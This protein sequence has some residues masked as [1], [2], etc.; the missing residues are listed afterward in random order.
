MNGLTDTL[1]L[2]LVKKAPALPPGAKE[3]IVKFAPWI[4]LIL[5]VLALPAVLAL[6]GLGTVLAPFAYMGG[7]SAGTGFTLSLVILAIS[8]VLE[9]LAIPGLFKRTKQGWNLVF[10]STLL[11]LVSSLVSYNIVGGLISALIGLYILFQV[12]SYY[13]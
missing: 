10:Y 8:V 2:Y 6:I 12:R 5:L 3:V 11:S 4:T 9:A 13:H 7:V 1:E